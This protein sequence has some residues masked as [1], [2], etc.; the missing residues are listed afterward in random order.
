M[1][2]AF[3]ESYYQTYNSED[4]EALAEFYH[5]EI[6]LHSAQGTTSGVDA[7]L[8]VY[9]SLIGV[10]EDQ[11]EPT[12]IEIDGDMATVTIVDRFTAKTEIEDFMGMKLSQG[13]SF[14]L[15]LRGQY[16]VKDGKFISI[17]IAQLAE[18]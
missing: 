15:Q 11:M 10:F 9:R 12:S 16:Q 4:P 3:I 17:T 6:Q 14:E 2:K 8:D 1:D 18:S 13:D 7:M 5:P